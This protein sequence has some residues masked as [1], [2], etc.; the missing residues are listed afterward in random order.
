MICNA[1]QHWQKKVQRKRQINV[2]LHKKVFGVQTKN[3]ATNCLYNK[4]IN[5][6]ALIDYR[7][8]K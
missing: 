5:F 3:Y 8:I 2:K 7:V 1:C 6:L 4:L